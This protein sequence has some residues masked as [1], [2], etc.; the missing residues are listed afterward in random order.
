MIHTLV[1]LTLVTV[2]PQ[3]A[4]PQQG[5]V[6]RIT[7][8][9]TGPDGT[10]SPM[11]S[12]LVSEEPPSREPRLIRIGPDGTATLRLAPGKYVVESD[13]PMQLGGAGYAWRQAGSEV[14]PIERRG[15]HVTGRRESGEARKSER[16]RNGTPR[17]AGGLRAG[18][19]AACAGVVPHGAPP[20]PT[21][22]GRR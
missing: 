7:L 10:I 1:L 18:R 16:D 12:L 17:S 3:A 15:N 8:A 9:L 11:H 13:K 5:G 14:A 4:A 21:T 19:A 20:D 2:L 22:A 6:L